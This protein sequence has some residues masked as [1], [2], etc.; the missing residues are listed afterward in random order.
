MVLDAFDA[1]HDDFRV[2]DSFV[3]ELLACVV[4]GRGLPDTLR[5]TGPGVF[6]R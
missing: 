4:H 6:A 1:G 2:P 3:Q 5:E